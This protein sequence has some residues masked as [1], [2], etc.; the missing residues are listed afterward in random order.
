VEIPENPQEVKALKQR[1]VYIAGPE[2]GEHS[3]HSLRELIQQH[4]QIHP[5]LR[6]L[7]P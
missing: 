1:R 2:W 7:H 4:E 3:E 6:F 5:I